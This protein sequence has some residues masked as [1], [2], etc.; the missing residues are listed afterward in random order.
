[1]PFY[2]ESQDGIQSYRADLFC[3]KKVLVD[4]E[5]YSLEDLGFQ[6]WLRTTSQHKPPQKKLKAVW[7]GISTK[8]SEEKT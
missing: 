7:Y 5:L 4:G 3:S 1:M 2:L 6:D 8:T